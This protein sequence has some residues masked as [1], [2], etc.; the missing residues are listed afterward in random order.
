MRLHTGLFRKEV[1]TEPSDRV[2]SGK[3][4]YRN[5]NNITIENKEI[6][7]ISGDGIYLENCSNV[8]IRNCLIS[9]TTRWGVF[10]LRCNGVVL[11]DCD[12]EYNIAGM[13]AVSST[14]IVAK[15]S[16]FKT[17][18]GPVPC[19][20]FFQLDKCYGYNAF[21]N[22]RGLNE[23]NLGDPEDCV[24]LY[25]CNGDPD[26]PILIEGNYIEGGG[27][28]ASGGGIMTGDQGGSWQVVRRNVIVNPGQYGIGVAGGHDI[29][30]ENNDVYA[31]REY[32]TN[33]G[34]YAWNQYNGANCYNVTI[35]D[36]IVDWTSKSG[37]KNP[38]W[39]GGNVQNLRV[40]DNTFHY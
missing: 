40:E 27:P 29:L 34:I 3:I 20:Q 39:D 28:S 5:R 16:R 25:K 38:F 12:V 6:R 8:T 21:L 30:I 19:G 35:K 24:S 11:E 36:N 1:V 13:Y 18:R 2:P 33:V 26:N 32:F 14:G 17:P 9:N 10:A 22:N 37:T 15:D 7:D 23:F 31:E 4:S